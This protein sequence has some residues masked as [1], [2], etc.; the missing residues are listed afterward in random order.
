MVGSRAEMDALEKALAAVQRL[1][2]FKAVVADIRLQSRNGLAAV[3]EMSLDRTEFTAGDRGVLEAVTR[4][5]TRLEIPVS[6]VLRM[7]A[8][9]C[10]MWWRNL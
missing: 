8:A 5:G 7:T 3:W 1:M 4:S 10:G 6:A 9:W 2:S